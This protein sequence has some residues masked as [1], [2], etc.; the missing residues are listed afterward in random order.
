MSHRQSISRVS[1]I[2]TAALAL[3]LSQASLLSAEIL[4][5]GID[6][7]FAYDDQAKR[8]ALA[9]GR[10]EVLFYDLKD[11]AKPQLI[12]SLPL[13]NSIVGPPTNIAITPDQKLALIANAYWPHPR[14]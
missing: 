6:R 12:G 10:D 13:E 4:A 1:T 3:L 14:I 11:P 2:C 8:Q 5:V 7:K 9:P